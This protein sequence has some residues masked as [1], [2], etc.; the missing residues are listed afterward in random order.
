[1][2]QQS[3]DSASEVKRLQR[4]MNDLVSVLALP[5]IWTGSEPDRI[6]ETF[7]DALLV[8][9]DLDFLYARVLLEAHESQIDA[10]RTSEVYETSHGSKEIRQAL[11]QWSG[12]VPQRWPEEVL[13]Q[14][15]GQEI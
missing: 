4:C 3:P 14:F 6:L 12:E 8:M 1:M 2:H 15:G 9:L 13:R 7:L 5:A 10:L 11:N